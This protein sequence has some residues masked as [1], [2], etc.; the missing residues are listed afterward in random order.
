MKQIKK[1]HKSFIKNDFFFDFISIF[2]I[3]L[4]PFAP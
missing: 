4:K 2:P 1:I 3:I